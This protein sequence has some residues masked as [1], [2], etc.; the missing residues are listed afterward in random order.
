MVEGKRACCGGN[1]FLFL[2]SYPCSYTHKGHGAHVVDGAEQQ[3]EAGIDQCIVY[4][5]PPVELATIESV[6]D[7][8]AH[9]LG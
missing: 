1:R 2:I 7:A 8:M 5:E 6:T 9:A 3:A 4:F